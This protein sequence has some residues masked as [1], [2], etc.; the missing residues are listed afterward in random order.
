MYMC[1]M[2]LFCDLKLQLR[3]AAAKAGGIFLLWK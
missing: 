2:R 1:V 3:V